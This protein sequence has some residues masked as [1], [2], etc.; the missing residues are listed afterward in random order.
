MTLAVTSL[1]V[2]ATI[3]LAALLSSPVAEKHP[4]GEVVMLITMYAFLV[5]LVVW[6]I[7]SVIS[8]TMGVR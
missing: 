2:A 8:A 5:A 4:A 7:L 1:I 6:V 3:G